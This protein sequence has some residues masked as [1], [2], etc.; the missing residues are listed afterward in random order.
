MSA[1]ALVS[2][3]KPRSNQSQLLG[4]SLLFHAFEPT[5]QPYVLTVKRAVNSAFVT[6]RSGK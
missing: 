1:F 5:C 6:T 3:A 4:R 2:F